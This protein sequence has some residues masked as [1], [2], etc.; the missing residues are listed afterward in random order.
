ML[1]SHLCSPCESVKLHS[2]SCGLLGREE[3]DKERG[4]RE[5]RREGGGD[6][7]RG[8]RETRRE[9][10]GGQGEREKEDKSEGKKRV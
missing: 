10:G 5:T 2:F 6:K 1:V 3:G 7:E 9:G 8:R 4:R